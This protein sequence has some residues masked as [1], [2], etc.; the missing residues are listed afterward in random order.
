MCCHAPR[1]AFPTSA[2]DILRYVE[3]K[4]GY[5]PS[6]RACTELTKNSNPFRVI[7]SFGNNIPT[8]P[9]W[10]E[11]VIILHARDFYQRLEPPK[12]SWKFPKRPSSSTAHLTSST[13]YYQN[14]RGLQTKLLDL[15]ISAACICVT[16]TWFD[17][18]IFNSKFLGGYSI[19]RWGKLTGVLVAVKQHVLFISI[20]LLSTR[21]YDA[22]TEGISPL[23]CVL[24]IISYA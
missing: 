11:S 12:P 7:M 4:L 1:P 2:E 16:E 6:P 22:I 8:Q 15:W 18:C 17:S 20:T 3:H 14:V 21:L 19:F 9:W 24:F 13:L 10:V 5:F 23:N